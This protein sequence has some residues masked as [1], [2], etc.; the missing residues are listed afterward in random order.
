MKLGC[1]AYFQF[2]GTIFSSSHFHFHNAL[3]LPAHLSPS[4]LSRTDKPVTQN[5]SRVCMEGSLP[6]PSSDREVRHMICVTITT[7]PS[8]APHNMK[9]S[10]PSPPHYS[11]PFNKCSNHTVH[12]GSLE[13]QMRR[14]I[15]NLWPSQ[16]SQPPS[17]S[18]TQPQ[19]NPGEIFITNNPCSLKEVDCI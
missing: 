2:S 18:P 19:G 3:F 13:P 4:S 12:V 1:K 10:T 14:K 9:H 17:F 7:V 6:T 16:H 15:C 11:S 8:N 5:L